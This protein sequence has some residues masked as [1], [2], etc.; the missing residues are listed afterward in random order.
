MGIRT[1]IFFG[2]FLLCSG[3]ACCCP[4]LAC[5]DTWPTTSS[6]PRA[7]GGPLR[8]G[9]LRYAILSRWPSWRPSES[10]SI[11]KASFRPS[12]WTLHEKLLV[13]FV[14]FGV[15]AASNL[16]TDDFLHAGRPSRR[17]S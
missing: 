7:S 12:F 10:R 2:L 13:A 15:A 1:V 3:G 11:S 4:C 8:F 16:R 6:V 14:G 5:W 17:K 9:R